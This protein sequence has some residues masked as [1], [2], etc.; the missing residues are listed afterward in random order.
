MG[1]GFGSI[2]P[3]QLKNQEKQFIFVIMRIWESYWWQC[4]L[5]GNRDYKIE[6]VKKTSWGIAPCG[7]ATVPIERPGITGESF[8]FN[9]EN[10]LLEML[11][12]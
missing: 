11:G 6:E 5:S 10:S 9:W 3:K 4:N 1:I 7:W 12:Q 2:R 8:H